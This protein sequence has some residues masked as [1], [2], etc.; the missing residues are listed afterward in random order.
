MTL[1]EKVGQLVQR[2]GGRQ[3]SLNSRID[4]A[5]LERVRA[6]GVGSYLHVAGAEPLAKLQKVAVEESRLGVPL[7]FAMDVVHG[8]RTIFPVPLAMAATWAPESEERAARVAA[9]EATAAGLHWTFA[10]MIDVARDPRWGR[11]V[12]GAGEDPYLGARMAVA[13]VNGFQGG[14]TLRPG[15]LMATAK[16]FGA[17]GAGIGGR[18]YNTADLSERTLQEVYLPPFYAAARA[19]AGS[20]MVAFNDIAGV[21]TTA[22]R[23]LVRGTLRE[24]WG[25]Q[26]LL[27]S[28]WGSIA[29]LLNHGVAAD[30][31]GAGL[32]ALDASV[33]MDMVGGVYAEDLKEAIAKDPARLK[34]LDEAVLRILRVKEQLGLFDKP[35]AY[36]DVEREKAALLSPEHREA[37]RA[38]A[39]QAIVLLKNDAKL[40]PLN[41]DKLRSIAVIGA[42]ATDGR[43]TIGSWKAQGHEE[44][45]VTL[46]KGIAAAAPRTL[47]IL[48]APGADPRNLDLSGIAAAVKVAKAADVTVLMIGEDYDLSGEARSRSDLELP[49]SQLELA[50]RVLATGKPVIV[51]LANGR[52]LAISEVAERA[53][54]ILETWM[55]GTEAGNAIADVL[56]G[57]YS[58]AGRLPA[59]FPRVSAAVPYTYAANPTGRPADPDLAKDTVR[60]HD[61]PI[62]PL[63]PFG[64]GLSYSEF[65][66]S[67]LELSTT[68]VDPG[69]RVDISIT[70]DNS[71]GIASDEVVQLYVRDPVASVERPVLELRGFKRV[72]LGAG[73]RKRVTF[74]LT[75]DQLAFWSPHGQWLIE[76]GRI[77]FWIGASSAD[78]RAK[79]SFEITKTH[80][81]TA[82]AAALPTRVTVS[83][84]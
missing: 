43:S 66:Y 25:W 38:V 80:A 32:L 78:L 48:S 34:L 47:K 60:Y 31:A 44:E 40:L 19:G 36:N 79:G 71:G 1:D 39:R 27:V 12:E 51:I 56:F 18:D 54:A 72:E 42:L 6:G 65:R 7:L 23:E 16:H 62:T 70:I 2:A 67:N 59:A 73:Q 37:A 68:T 53:P 20:F 29:E 30:R 9:D 21:P 58:P 82:P 5:E 61:L 55:L 64:H 84:N 35:F 14:N 69:G 15:S 33:D 81:G 22:N 83:N 13:Q 74:S 46:L 3:R 11:I 45:A 24:H 26:G 57:K 50:R 8:Y 41:A 17:Y 10:P 63:Y 4:D 28:D 77:D 52:P 75:P 76:A 49:P